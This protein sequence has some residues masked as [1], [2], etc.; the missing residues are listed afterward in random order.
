MNIDNITNTNNIIINRNIAH[1]F[2]LLTAKSFETFP[3]HNEY[4]FILESFALNWSFLLTKANVVF[5]IYLFPTPKLR[6]FSPQ[7]RF[8][9]EKRE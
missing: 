6:V 3:K 9:N 2:M 5:F 1:L 7:S 8:E 4:A